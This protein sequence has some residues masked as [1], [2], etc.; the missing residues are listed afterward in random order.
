MKL[1]NFDTS[2]VTDMH[3]MFY[4][5]DCYSVDLSNFDTSNVTNMSEMFRY[6]YSLTDVNLSGFD[7]SNVTDMS[8]IFMYCTVL[9]T[10]YMDKEDEKIYNALSTNTPSRT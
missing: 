3:R 4:G 1:E 2:N 6:S 7:T 10:V 8:K 5:C 9:K